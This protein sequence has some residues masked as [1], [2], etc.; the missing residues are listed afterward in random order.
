M[1]R[2]FQGHR[3]ILQWVHYICQ[4]GVQVQIS[5]QEIPS[6]ENW[7][8]ITVFDHCYL[9]TTFLELSYWW[10]EHC[11]SEVFDSSFQET[12]FLELSCLQYVLDKQFLVLEPP[13]DQPVSVFDPIGN[14]IWNYTDKLLLWTIKEVKLYLL[15][16]NAQFLIKE[17]LI[18]LD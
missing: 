1:I 6:L 2:I 17:K 7:N 4:E 14:I 16:S 10:R 15:K 3:G 12:P 11:N 13:P 5:C 9:R 8:F 18:K